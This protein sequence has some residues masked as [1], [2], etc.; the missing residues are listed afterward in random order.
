MGDGGPGGDGVTATFVVAGVGAT[1]AIA[2]WWAGATPEAV[3]V[4][5]AAVGV[6]VV[7]VAA[8]AVVAVVV[9]V[10]VGSG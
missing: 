3:A 8:V 6:T 9:A 2:A 1:V 7:V 10:V 4:T 5:V